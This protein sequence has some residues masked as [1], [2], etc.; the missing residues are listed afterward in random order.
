MF[1]LIF[2]WLH[3]IELLS[4]QSWL[5]GNCSYFCSP[6]VLTRFVLFFK[7]TTLWSSLVAQRVRIHCC[8][9]CGLGCSSGAGLIW[10][11]LRATDMTPPKP[12]TSKVFLTKN[13]YLFL[14][15]RYYFMCFPNTGLWKRP[16]KIRKFQ[17]WTF[18]NWVIMCLLW[19]G[20]ILNPYPHMEHDHHIEIPLCL[21]HQGKNCSDF[22][23]HRVSGT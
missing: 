21:Y 16:K 10:E 6:R 3:F 14:F 15:F 8:H 1:I 11:L 5:K 13:M 20:Q 9:C 19:N 4:F 12:Q 2:K 18:K 17:G 7:K 22:Q 23:H